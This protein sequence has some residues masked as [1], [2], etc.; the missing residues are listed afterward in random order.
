MREMESDTKHGSTYCVRFVER[1]TQHDYVY[2]Q[3][4]IGCHSKIGRAGGAPELSLG[5]GCEGKGT[6]MHELNHALG[7]WH[8]QNRYDRDSYV[9]IHL[10][11]IASQHHHDFAKRTSRD[12]Q[13]LGTPYDFGSIMHYGAYTF[14]VDKSRPSISPKSGMG[15]GV[16]MGQRLAM[17]TQDV[18]RIQKLYECT[19]ETT[20]ITHPSTSQDVINCNF[21]DDI[22]QFT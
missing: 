6:I 10:D 2:I 16:T 22:C 15:E 13:L 20:H 9:T 11:N 5:T 21:D 12:M 4:N 8:E 3:K 18:T 17:S 19:V 1:T 7:F 14:A